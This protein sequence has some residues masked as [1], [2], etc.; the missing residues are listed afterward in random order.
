MAYQ[1][2][3]DAYVERGMEIDA[4]F[5]LQPAGRIK[6]WEDYVRRKESGQA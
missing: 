2:S 5:A 1:D 6:R 4:R 3:L